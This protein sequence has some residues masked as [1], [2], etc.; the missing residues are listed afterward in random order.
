MNDKKH[1]EGR[2]TTWGV[3]ASR[4]EGPSGRCLASGEVTNPAAVHAGWRSLLSPQ[5]IAITGNGDWFAFV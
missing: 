2:T 4:L 1:A 3:R 5:Q